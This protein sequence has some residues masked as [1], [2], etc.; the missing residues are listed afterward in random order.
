MDG[1]KGIFPRLQL[2]GSAISTTSH[3]TG[4]GIQLS[5]GSGVVMKVLARAHHLRREKRNAEMSVPDDNEEQKV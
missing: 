2:E 5:Q 3:I 4:R 1:H